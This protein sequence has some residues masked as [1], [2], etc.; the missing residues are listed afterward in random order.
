MKVKITIIYTLLF[1]LL[2]QG[3]ID[4]QQVVWSEASDLPSSTRER[5]ASFVIGDHIYVVG[6]RISSGQNTS[7]NLVYNTLTDT[8]ISKANIPGVTRRNAVGFSDGQYGY[9]GLG[10]DGA[11]NLLDFWRYDP[12][13]NEWSSIAD[14]P[15]EGGSWATSVFLQGKG[16]VMFGGDSDLD[17]YSNEIW[18]YT[19][20]TDTWILKTTLPSSERRRAVGFIH[21]GKIYAG[22]G[23]TASQ[24]FSD[25]WEYDI[26]T[27]TWTQKAS[28]PTAHSKGCFS[29]NIE[30]Q[31]VIGGCLNSA[32]NNNQELFMYDPLTN[33]WAQ[34][35]DFPGDPRSHTFSEQVDNKG[36]VG[37]GRNYNTSTYFK[38][39]YMAELAEFYTDFSYSYNM[40][41]APVEV[42]F[43]DEGNDAIAWEWEFPG[44]S[45]SSSTEQNPTV[46]YGSEGIYGASLFAT[47]PTGLGYNSQEDI[48]IV[49]DIPN[50]GFAF[51]QNGNEVI[52]ENNSSNADSYSW[53][54]GNGDSSTE[55][56][57]TYSYTASGFY[58]ITL[59]AINE[60]GEDESINSL[61]IEVVD[62]S[63]INDRVELSCGPNPF[64]KELNV[65]YDLPLS[66]SN[67]YIILSNSLGQKLIQQQVSYAKGNAI[68]NTEF[69]AGIYSLYLEVD[70][71][72]YEA[73]QVVKN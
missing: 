70:G 22:L 51:S 15:G 54:F 59:T 53:D 64:S 30:G 73:V 69:P 23:G 48:I 21:E 60:C 32:D 44:G 5:T 66:F 40:E 10:Y 49:Y 72:V 3:S 2:F 7:Q 12:V 9:V 33:T 52:F 16:Y 46:V 61:N 13:N 20:D 47:T 36:Y 65:S 56:N 50:A 34:H 58:T 11:G 1:M 71:N 68:F 45:P 19:P 62:V 6:G 25:F 63:T 55:E 4:A 26:D 43:T 57:P 14:F 8:W 18:E 28:F 67:A 42:A 17:N 27:D 37:T 41:C 39:F 29:F 35:E 38:D 24:V 31:L